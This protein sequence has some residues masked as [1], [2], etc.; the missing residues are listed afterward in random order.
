MSRLDVPTRRTL[1]ILDWDKTLSKSDTLSLIAPSPEALSPYTQ[2]YVEYYAELRKKHGDLSTASR[3]TAFLDEMEGESHTSA[4]SR[5][6][7]S[8]A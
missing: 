3:M 1:V 2:A 5:K 8:Y 4:L 7:D 6:A